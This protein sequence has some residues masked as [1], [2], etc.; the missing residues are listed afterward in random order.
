MAF[1]I[2]III[3]CIGGVLWG[4]DLF[5]DGSCSLARRLKVSEIVIGLTIVALG[6]SLPEFTVSFMSVLSGSSNMSVGNIMGSNVFNILVI[7]GSSAIMHNIKV[8]ST[9]LRRDIPLCL[10]A[11]VMLAIFAL[12]GDKISRLE[13][14]LLVAFFCVYLYI[15][16]RVALAD[17]RTSSSSP[18]QNKENMF[19]IVGRIL[20]GVLVLVVFGRVLVVYASKV[21]IEWGISESVV[22]MTILAA[23][24]SLPELATSI[25]AARKGSVGLAMGNVIGS[26]VFNIA[27]VIG[28]CG[29]IMPMAVTEIGMKDWIV[30]VGSCLLVWLVAWTGRKLNR[31]EG[32]LLVAV[33]LAYLISLFVW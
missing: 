10:V 23:G 18:V 9:L 31:K 22:G 33:Y 27:F 20:F 6:T 4:A 13:A 21:A 19:L 16:F 3:L 26:N 30:F 1:E 2:F 14:L 29:S 24:T 7:T 5:T 32:I 17:R 8:E 25:V 11:S 28:T 15:V 12:T